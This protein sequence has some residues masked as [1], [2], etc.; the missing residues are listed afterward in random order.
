MRR[1]SYA[2][3]PNAQGKPPI[4][5]LTIARVAELSRR[6]ARHVLQVF[7]AASMMS[8]GNLLNDLYRS[9]GLGTPALLLDGGQTLSTADLLHNVGTY[10]AALRTLGVQPGDRV[11]FQLD[12]CPEAL[13]LAHACLMVGAIMHPLNPT[14]TQVETESLLRDARPVLFVCAPEEGDASSA[15]SLGLRLETLAVGSGG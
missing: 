5:A 6:S 9:R 8:S 11:S 13:F 2:R 12:K 3:K 15:K 4:P 14:Y 1:P 7:E 10:A